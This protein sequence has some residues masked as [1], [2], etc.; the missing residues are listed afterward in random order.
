MSDLEDFPVASAMQLCGADISEH[1]GKHRVWT[2]GQEHQASAA[3]H[4]AD[5]TDEMVILASITDN[6]SSG[7]QYSLT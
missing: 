6:V 5:G 7:I 1:G 3:Q 4:A 2:V